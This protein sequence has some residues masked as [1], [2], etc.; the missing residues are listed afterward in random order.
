[1]LSFVVAGCS[2]D[3]ELAETDVHFSD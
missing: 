2:D 3:L 1:L